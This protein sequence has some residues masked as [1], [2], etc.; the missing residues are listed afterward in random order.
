MRNRLTISKKLVIIFF[1]IGLLPL[2]V[3]GMISSLKV[4]NVMKEQVMKHLL[5]LREL[6]REQ[7]EEYLKIVKDQSVQHS[8][9]LSVISAVSEFT[10]AFWKVEQEL[11]V[12]YDSNKGEFEKKLKNRYRYQREHTYGS[13]V[14]SLDKWWP[15]E[16]VTRILQHLYISSNPKD[17]GRKYEYDYSSDGSTYSKVHKKY[18]PMMRKLFRSII[19]Y[20]DIFLIE[21]E[22]G[23]IVYSTFKEVDFGTSLMTG[24]YRKSNLAKV[25]RKA[26]NL[27]VKDNA[28][29]A[30]FSHYEPS[31]NKPAAF[32]SS[33]V[34][35][36]DTLTGILV[37]QLSIHKIDEIMTSQRKWEH[38]GMGRS[39][40]TYLVGE[41]MLMRSDSRFF[42]ENKEKYI[43][44][45][46]KQGYNKALIK[47]MRA[48]D[49]TILLQEV[50]TSGVKEAL[51]GSE[52][53]GLFPDYRNVPVLGAYT[54]IHIKGLKWVLMSEIDRD[55]AFSSIENLTRVMRIVT[56]IISV[57]VILSSIVYGR[58]ISRPI[59][60]LA[61]AAKD[62][63]KGKFT[64]RVDVMSK[65]EIGQLAETFNKMSIELQES[66]VSKEEL[67]NLV[68]K[69]TDDLKKINEQLNAVMRTASD[70][71]ITINNNGEIIFWNEAAGSI[72]GLSANEVIGAPVTIIMPERFRESHKS[73]ISRIISGEA[74]KMIG[75][76]IE[77]VGL[78][79]KGSEFPLE[80]S[81][82]SWVT[83]EGRF[84][85]GI[86]RDISK[87]K[88][89]EESLFKS[90]QKYR[91]LYQEF[92]TLLD[93]IPDAIVQLSPDL[94]IVWANNSMTQQFSDDITGNY[95][96]ELLHGYKSVCYDCQALKSFQSGKPNSDE[97]T[98]KDGKVW[99]V[100]A[101]PVK[102]DSGK[103][104][105]VIEI[106]TEITEKIHIQAET[107]RTA[108]LASLGELS[109]GVAHEI[110]NPV[111]SIINYGRVILD[112]LKEDSKEYEYSNEII[113]EGRR[114]AGIVRA[115][116]S[117]ARV[118]KDDKLP[119]GIQKVLDDTLALTKR[120]IEKDGILIETNIADNLPEININSQQI[121]QVFLNMLNNARYALNHKK[122]ENNQTK[123]LKISCKLKHNEDISVASFI[124]YDNGTGIPADIGEKVLNPFFTTKPAGEG[125]GLGLSISHGIISDHNGKIKV[126][127]IEGEYTEI[128][129]DLP[130]SGKVEA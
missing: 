82:G 2:I 7:I 120:Q 100:K 21:P 37:F 50:N 30:D 106:A 58:N 1:I 109:A 46:K 64:D 33:P 91:K 61:D 54:P 86:V 113:K 111:N 127:S 89:D 81:L 68:E 4:R 10:D 44:L 78:H 15:E 80:L 16:K 87:R 110:N 20:Y 60:K 117:F 45:L 88:K 125:M 75:G 11:S 22:Q 24:P 38:R 39:V 47:K 27:K 35:D 25:F 74:S 97:R 51:K 70:G 107:I 57:L 118:K 13:A 94:K 105:S 6:K 76:T 129:V 66:T 71:I 59:R 93:S 12:W 62:I 99:E 40:K 28:Y 84:F 56:V 90:E 104:V 18:H 31:Y 29:I 116:L 101:F 73:G 32:V 95:C 103:I 83:A 85:T 77:T 42:S 128:T 123:I 43:S 48:L 121:Q 108:H 67:E 9:D 14:N 55:E 72:F 26:L 34:F 53:A 23:Y 126:D 49:T 79:K 65:D 36:D 52:G 92:H 17:L 112:K 130:V 3:L 19:E 69:R 96:Y 122:F 119:I 124:F 5:S 63:G 102:D 115:L 114:I 8:N 41:D 98:T